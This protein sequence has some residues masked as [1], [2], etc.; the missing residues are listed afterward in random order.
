MMIQK[1][2]PTGHSLVPRQFLC[3]RGIILCA[4]CWG[5]FLSTFAFSEDN[6]ADYRLWFTPEKWIDAFVVSP[7]LPFDRQRF[8]N[9][10]ARLKQ[11]SEEQSDKL[12]HLSRIVLNAQLEGR[13]LTSGQ[14]FFTLHPCSDHT[15]SILLNPFTLAVNSLRWLDDT[16]A[17]LFCEPDGGNR[18]LIPSDT[19]SHSYDQLQ[20]RWSLQSRRDTRNGIVFDLALPPCMSIELQLDLPDSMVL[21]A[22]AGLVL[23]DDKDEGAASGMRTWRVLLGHHSNTTLTITADKTLLPVRQKPT[24]RQVTNYF[25]TPEGL[26][27]VARV[28]SMGRIPDRRNYCW[29]WKC[30]FVPSKSGTAIVR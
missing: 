20:F 4:F 30:R 22:S 18:L 12:P 21:T 8:E 10:L 3:R 5:L 15:D 11:R 7:S 19:D 26:E 29:N 16:E 24:I 23:P 2:F 25:I 14:G 9:L 17:I 6:A 27:T 28:R 13:Q 1:K